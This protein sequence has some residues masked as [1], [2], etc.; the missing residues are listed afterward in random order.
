MIISVRKRFVFV[1]IPKTAGSSMFRALAS[2][3]DAPDTDENRHMEWIRIA[4]NARTL[5]GR[6][7][8]TPHLGNY[9][10]FA[11]VRN[12]WDRVVSMYNYRLRNREIPPDLP[13]PEFIFNRTDYPFGMHREQVKLIEDSHGKIAMDFIGRFENLEKDWAII[14][15]RLKI[16]CGLPHLKATVHR[17]YQTYYHRE[18]VDEI[19]RM[20]PRDIQLFGYEF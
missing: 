5:V 15:D 9:F 1:H 6:E 2:Y 7:G 12:P 14:Q 11:F 20:Y 3:N 18:L 17:P 8:E 10:K 13:F 19:A 4:E 16:S